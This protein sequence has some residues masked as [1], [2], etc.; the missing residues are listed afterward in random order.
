MD[1][2]IKI[3]YIFYLPFPGSIF[4]S[5]RI[6]FPYLFTFLLIHPLQSIFITKVLIPSKSY[7]QTSNMLY[8]YS[9]DIEHTFYFI[10]YK[11]TTNQNNSLIPLF[12]PLYPYHLYPYK[13]YTCYQNSN[14]YPSL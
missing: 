12:P 5:N 10:S 7:L 6:L 13:H 3:S 9:L 4:Y 11:K 2:T 1:I 8:L 14:K